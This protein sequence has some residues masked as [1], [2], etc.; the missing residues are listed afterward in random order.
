[1]KIGIFGGTFDPIHQGHMSLARSAK[2][3]FN[4]DK[5]FFV[6]AFIP[7]HK[8]SKQDLTPA[9]YRYRMVEL[10]LRDQPEFEISDAEFNRPEVSYT[11]ETLRLFKRKFPEADVYLV[12]G[13]DSL[14]QIPSWK[15]SGEIR[16]LA[17]LLV[18]RRP[19]IEI[20]RDSKDI[21]WIEM[22]EIQI[23]SSQL[24]ERLAKGELFPGEILPEGVGEYITKMRLYQKGNG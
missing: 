11:V 14:A 5:I 21:Q 24:R 16:K 9:P 6:P 23:S 7:P 4:L 22:P 20:P 13:A 10:A 17:N 12:L 15:E 1:M 3:Q 19:G 2:K 18:A 8:S